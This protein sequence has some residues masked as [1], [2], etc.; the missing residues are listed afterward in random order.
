MSEWQ[1]DKYG[2]SIKLETWVLSITKKPGFKTWVLNLFQNS[3][4][5]MGIDGDAS[6]EEVKA[7]A[8]DMAERHLRQTH[9]DIMVKIQQYKG[10]KN[11]EYSY[12]RK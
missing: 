7:R 9:E 10:V 4:Y 3:N 11:N 12:S 2:Y 1:K 5:V 8:L 6:D